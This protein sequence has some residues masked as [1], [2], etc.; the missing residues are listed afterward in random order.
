MISFGVLPSGQTQLLRVRESLLLLFEQ[1]R[2]VSAPGRR[3]A[4]PGRL[5]S[6]HSDKDTHSGS[7][8]PTEHTQFGRVTS[9]RF[10]R[11]D[12]KKS[13]FDPVIEALASWS[14]GHSRHC[15]SA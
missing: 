15:G 11:S 7:K 1:K 4:N 14:P 5:M 9:A 6:D 13:C 2:F 10:V 8:N 12:L 3:Q